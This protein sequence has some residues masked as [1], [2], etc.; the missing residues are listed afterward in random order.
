[1]QQKEPDRSLT[2]TTALKGA[3][4]YLPSKIRQ[5]EISALVFVLLLNI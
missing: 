2:L 5:K 1:M 4:F 3:V